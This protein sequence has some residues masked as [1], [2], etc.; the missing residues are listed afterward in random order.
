MKRQRCPGLL[1]LQFFHSW[2][3][4][5]MFLGAYGLWA[6]RHDDSGHSL[7]TGMGQGASWLRAEYQWSQREGA[8]S[9]SPVLPLPFWDFRAHLLLAKG[10]AQNSIQGHSQVT[11]SQHSDVRTRFD[12]SPSPAEAWLPCSAS[13]PLDCYITL[14]GPIFQ[15]LVWEVWGFIYHR[16][17]SSSFIRGKYWQFYKSI[18]FPF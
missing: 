6:I 10:Q 18:S 16:L 3:K 15:W 1:T 11:W 9:P 7:P 14:R 17:N 5:R 8:G 2:P 4:D 12:P 13:P